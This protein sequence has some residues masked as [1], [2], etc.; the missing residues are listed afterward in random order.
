MAH[1]LKVFSPNINDIS[2]TWK[3]KF[4]PNEYLYAQDMN[5]AL[6]NATVGI[7]L[8]YN[9]IDD[10]SLDGITYT[11][12]DFDTQATKIKNRLMAMTNAN[13]ATNTTFGTIKTGYI[14]S[15]YKL[16]VELDTEGKAFV[17]I[18]K[19]ETATKATS[20]DKA[21]LADKTNKINTS[22][23]IGATN[24][25]VYVDSNGNI[26]ACN[27]NAMSVASATHATTAD[28]AINATNSANATNASKSVDSTYASKIGSST[29]H[30]SIGSNV[31][32]VYVDSNG[33]LQECSYSV[34]T[35]VPVNAKFTDTTAWSGITNKI[36]SSSTTQ[37]YNISYHQNF[38]KTIISNIAGIVNI[39]VSV[40]KNESWDGATPTITIKAD[41]E[42]L[43]SISLGSSG[44]YTIKYYDANTTTIT[45]EV[46]TSNN[47][48]GNSNV[49]VSYKY[50][51]FN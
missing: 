8:F 4:S 39:Y 45:L 38:N 49:G 43:K 17:N 5:L 41:N 26:K 33:N 12:T 48:K 19:A 2:T 16:P 15:D 25:P 46:N 32:P 22:I 3:D 35:N 29:S 28:S 27:T 23:A 47:T 31:K 18:T 14:V 24:N 1:G 36:T 11:T 30:P 6:R 50:I 44:S 10:G 34:N 21:T 9:A 37:S 42:I 40:E 13:K 51:K 7:V 20:A